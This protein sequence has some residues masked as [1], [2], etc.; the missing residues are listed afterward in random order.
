M[1]LGNAEI[2][3]GDRLTGAAARGDIAEVRHLLHL[4]LVHPDSH[5][6]FGKTA[7]QVSEASHGSCFLEKTVSPG[8]TGGLGEEAL[9]LQFSPA[10]V[11]SHWF[12]TSRKSGCY[13]KDISLNQKL[14]LDFSPII[15]YGHSTFSI[16][17]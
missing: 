12:G 9:I 3:A 10:S 14:I 13:F 15:D 11:H 7:L 1:Q 2:R 16:F 17:L 8:D 4:E 6:R 5:N